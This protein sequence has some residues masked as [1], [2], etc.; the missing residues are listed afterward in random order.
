MKFAVAVLL[1]FA[2]VSQGIKFRPDPVQSPWA[3]KKDDPKVTKITDGFSAHKDY[4]GYERQVPAI[5]S[6]ESDD[7]LMHS[8]IKNYATE[9][10]GADGNGNG[11]FYLTRADALLV[12]GEIGNTH[13]GLKGDNLK[14]FVQTTGNMAFDTVDVGHEGFVD[15]MKGPVFCRYVLDEPEVS[16][17]LQVQ[18]DA[19]IN[20]GV[21]FRPLNTI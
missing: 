5:Y 19:E 10:K 7:R 11:K 8:L 14:N 18:T 1:G 6:E 13:L 21:R 20:L 15:I 12:A 9:G 16:N 2:S 17:A 4:E 3:A